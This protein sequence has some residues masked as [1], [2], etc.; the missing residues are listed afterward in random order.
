MPAFREHHLRTGQYLHGFGGSKGGHW[1]ENGH[2]L[3]ADTIFE[4]LREKGIVP[5]SITDR[6][7]S[8]DSRPELNSA[9][10]RYSHP[11]QKGIRVH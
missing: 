11:P 10:G 4:F 3:A 1:N 9:D 5:L 8:D 2:R 7:D 6:E